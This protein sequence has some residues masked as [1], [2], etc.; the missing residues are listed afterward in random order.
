MI[1]IKKYIPEKMRRFIYILSLSLFPGVCLSIILFSNALYHDIQQ[2]IYRN[3]LPDTDL[4][5]VRI[6][7]RMIDDTNPYICIAYP[8]TYKFNWDEDGGKETW[9]NLTV[10]DVPMPSYKT[11]LET[12]SGTHNM[13]QGTRPLEPYSVFLDRTNNIELRFSYDIVGEVD[14]VSMMRIDNRSTFDFLTYR[15]LLSYDQ[16]G[17]PFG[18]MANSTYGDALTD[19]GH[20]YG[21]KLF[22]DW[23]LRG[24]KNNI[25]D[26]FR[27]NRFLFYLREYFYIPLYGAVWLYPLFWGISKRRLRWILPLI[28]WYPLW[29]IFCT[30]TLLALQ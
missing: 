18:A 25:I 12:L 13:I 20:S 19:Y 1:E 26:I 28:V 23:E 5:L 8:A 2:Q 11:A 16:I 6:E 22:S 29:Y 27:T 4:S 15:K 9:H 17:L 14:S 24:I 7:G 30:L 21:P 3:S 10:D